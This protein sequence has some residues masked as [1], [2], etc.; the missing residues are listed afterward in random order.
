[1]NR[2]FAWRLAMYWPMHFST[3]NQCTS[4]WD[5]NHPSADQHTIKVKDRRHQQLFTKN[6]S[7]TVWSDT[8]KI[9][10][11]HFILPILFDSFTRVH[12][13]WAAAIE[14]NIKMRNY[15]VQYWSQP[16]YSR[17]LCIMHNVKRK[18]NPSHC[19]QITLEKWQLMVLDLVV[20]VLDLQ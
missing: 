5:L 2:L 16:T 4:R 12:W 7:L 18:K 13:N 19:I 9:N 11:S 6:F 1:M 15:S 10:D 17:R 3:R 20:F 14:W 8:E